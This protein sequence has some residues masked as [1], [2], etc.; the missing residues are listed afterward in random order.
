MIS[1]SQVNNADESS[2]PLQS[3]WRRLWKTVLPNKIKIIFWRAYHDSLPIMKELVHKKITMKNTCGICKS[4]P[5]DMFH[6]TF[7]CHN[8][9][10]SWKIL[11]PKMNGLMSSHSF[12]SITREV[13]IHD[14][15]QSLDKLMAVV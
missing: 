10:P 2:S 1:D 11:F 3:F 12:L 9:W 13:S 15:D 7:G 5:E 14:K 6:V 8:I 4:A